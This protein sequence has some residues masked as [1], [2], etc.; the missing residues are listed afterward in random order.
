MLAAV[1][2]LLAGCADD[3]GDADAAASGHAADVRFAT[4]MIPHHA[5]ALQMVDLTLG[6]NLSPEVEELAEQVRTTQT[7]EIETMS[8][9]LEKWGEPVPATSRDHLHAEHGAEREELTELESATGPA[10]EERWLALTAEHHETAVE[11]ARAEIED[12][13]YPPAVALAE[14]IE[15]TQ[16]AEIDRIR[17]LLDE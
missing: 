8:D 3:Q 10:F 5:E 1:L 13:A 12:G 15:R 6:R 7:G 9:W 16:Q 2:L 17:A 14:S 11:I 4:A